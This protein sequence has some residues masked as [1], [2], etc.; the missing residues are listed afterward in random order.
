MRAEI[1]KGRRY[2]RP[3]MTNPHPYLASARMKH[4]EPRLEWVER[5]LTT[6]FT[7][8]IDETHS[9]RVV[10]YCYI[11]EAGTGKWLM[12]IVQ[13]DRLFNAYFNRDLLKTWGRTV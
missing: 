2:A 8:D 1:K 13:D 9:G 7:A 3:V 5:T 6:P 12:V 11:P 10:Y 4:P